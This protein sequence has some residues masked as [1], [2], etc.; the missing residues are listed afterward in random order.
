[1]KIRKVTSLNDFIAQNEENW[2]PIH[3]WV[4]RGVPDTSFALRPTL[5]RHRIQNQ[6]WLLNREMCLLNEFK[7]LAPG[8][9]PNSPEGD[10]EWLCLARHH[11]LAT[12]L[13]DWTQNALVA[14]YFAAY[15]DC[16]CDFAVYSLWYSAWLGDRHEMSLEEIQKY[17]ESILYF[18][19]RT[20]ARLGSQSS[21]IL[22][23]NPPWDDY[24][25]PHGNVIKYIF[26][27]EGRN[28]IRY[29]LR[30]LGL[31]PSVIWADLEGIAQDINDE[32]FN[33]DKVKI[34]LPPLDPEAQKV[35]NRMKIAIEAAKAKTK[36]RARSKA[37]HGVDS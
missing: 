5:G 18:P 22:L 13:L 30:M 31:K 35:V 21:V 29:Q 4:Y 26:P 20:N 8:F 37:T 24:D 6:D 14:L 7:R 34:D 17:P 15:P 1:M 33:I 25:D 28:K 36:K 19:R 32:Y 23:C 9:I 12:R 16:N 11:G 2:H 27:S 3:H 10:L